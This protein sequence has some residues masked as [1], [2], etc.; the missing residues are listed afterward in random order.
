MTRAARFLARSS[1]FRATLFAAVLLVPQT[2]APLAWADATGPQPKLPTVAITIVSASG[3]RHALTVEL[4]L[5]D[6]QQET[7]EMGRPVIPEDQGMLFDW[8][9]PRVVPMWMKNT[10]APLD[11]LFIDD[12]GHIIH[13]AENAVPY[14]LASIDSGGKVRA[15]LEVAGGLAAKLDINVGDT[16]E[17]AMFAKK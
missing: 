9:T 2:L 11:M 5:T 1:L 10:M 3:A 13:I 15:T 16:V 14:S 7:G 8:H 4:A 6:A 12:T 17:G